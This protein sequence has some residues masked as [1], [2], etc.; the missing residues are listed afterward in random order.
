MEN[1]SELPDK[2]DTTSQ[3]GIT[4]LGYA[5]PGTTATSEAR[6]GIVKIQSD[7][8]TYPNGM[9]NYDQVWDDRLSLTYS[10]RKF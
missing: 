9:L 6:W 2:I 3:T 10:L 7:G 4:Y 8:T 5:K 1:L